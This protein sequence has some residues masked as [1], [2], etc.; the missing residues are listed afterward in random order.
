MKYNRFL[1]GFLTV[2]SVLAGLLSFGVLPADFLPVWSLLGGGAPRSNEEAV[3]QGQAR[4]SHSGVRLH[5]WL[6]VACFF[7]PEGKSCRW[8]GLLSNRLPRRLSGRNHGMR[9]MP[10]IGMLSR[11]PSVQA[12]NDCHV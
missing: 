3:E 12:G 4:G 8:G 10:L 9:A 11:K 1:L 6:A 5:M 2:C 7:V